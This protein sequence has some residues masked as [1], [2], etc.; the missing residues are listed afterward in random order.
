MFRIGD[1]DPA[2]GMYWV[3]GAD[4]SIAGLGRKLFDE[5]VQTGDKVTAGRR[6][7]GTWLLLGRD[8]GSATLTNRRRDRAVE[9]IE[10]EARPKK[11]KPEYRR[12]EIFNREEPEDGDWD[13]LRLSCTVH[14]YVR[15]RET[16][17][18]NF[19]STY[20]LVAA[21]P[22]RMRVDLN[23]HTA[24]IEFPGVGLTP[25][26]AIYAGG[27]AIAY[28]YGETEPENTLLWGPTT[29]SFFDLNTAGPWGGSWRRVVLV[30]DLKACRRAGFGTVANPVILEA[31]YDLLSADA[32]FFPI[33]VSQVPIGNGDFFNQIDKISGGRVI[34]RVHIDRKSAA[35]FLAP[36]PARTNAYCYPRPGNASLGWH[37][38]TP[39]KFN[40]FPLVGA[41]SQLRANFVPIGE[42]NG[43]PPLIQVGPLFNLSTY[44]LTPGSYSKIRLE[45]PRL[46]TAVGN[47]W[48]EI[49]DTVPGPRSLIART[50]GLPENV[51]LWPNYPQIPPFLPFWQWRS[52]ALPKP[53]GKSQPPKDPLL[54]FGNPRIFGTLAVHTEVNE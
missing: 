53:R 45:Y 46:E 41:I 4:G 29:N 3:I 38:G 9:P 18:S 33:E 8:G 21:A 37:S 50:D 1:R 19:Q 25:V 16:A 43:Y 7:D 10:Q 23:G 12:L 28:A 31:A 5:E 51:P 15:L 44:A 20:E 39:L 54:S 11:A 34:W 13:F 36:P 24:D 40:K 42:G 47:S 35:N 14:N 6:S 32:P 48:A 17:A 2:T 27:N 26:P 52:V 49:R 22:A 30:V